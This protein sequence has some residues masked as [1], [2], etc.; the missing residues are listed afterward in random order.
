MSVL[1]CKAALVIFDCIF[2][3]AK[4][5]IESVAVLAEIEDE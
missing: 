5:E 4:I 2:Q 3:G 1:K